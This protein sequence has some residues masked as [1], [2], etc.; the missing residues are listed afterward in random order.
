MSFSKEH[1]KEWYLEL[2][3]IDQHLEASAT[4]IL[5]SCE[6]LSN[7]VKDIPETDAVIANIF[8]NCNFHD[9][10]SQRLRKILKALSEEIH[11]SFGTREEITETPL[12]MH[13]SLPLQNG[14]Q[15]PGKAL[16]QDDI[17]N[18]LKST[19]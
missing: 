4:D 9:L 11:G 6:Q 10:N 1:L 14:P 17:E 8:S 16:S 13:A 12:D 5:E 3:T 2:N 15:R 7:L 19:L 18:L